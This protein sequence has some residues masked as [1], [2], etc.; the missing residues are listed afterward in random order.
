[1]LAGRWPGW[2][3]LLLTT[4]STAALVA[5]PAASAQTR[6]VSPTTRP[7]AVAP[8]VV[9]PTIDTAIRLA[10]GCAP[11]PELTGRH[12][13]EVLPRL[14]PELFRA[15][16]N[17][18]PS[19]QPRGTILRQPTTQL[20][21]GRLCWLD[22]AVSDGSLTRVPQLRGVTAGEAERALAAAD[23]RINTREKPSGERAGRIFDQKPDAGAEVPRGSMVVAI[24]A[25]ATER[26]S[27]ADAAAAAVAEAI[28]A[29]GRDAAPRP[30]QPEPAEETC[31]PLPV[32][33]GRS[34]D[35]VLPTLGRRYFR[36]RIGEEP[37]TEPR[38]TILRQ[39]VTVPIDGSLCYI[40]IAISDGSL[41]RVPQ[42]HGAT[43][44]EAE[45][46]LAEADLRIAIRESV[47]S[48]PAGRVF[49][50]KPRAGDEVPR[51]STVG[52]MIAVP[53]LFQVPDVMGQPYEEALA[54]LERFAVTRTPAASRRPPGEVTNQEPRPP[55]RRPAGAEVRL[56]VSDG[57]LVLVPPIE[58]RTLDSARA[59]LGE[60]DLR[61]EVEEQEGDL[62][63][64]LVA[65]QEPAGG[66]EVPRGSTVRVLVS[67]GLPVPDVVGRQLAEAAILLGRFEVQ[68][69]SLQARQP[70][71]EV[72]DQ[73]PRPPA[74][75]A[76]ASVVRVSV[77]D[78]S[79]VL[80]PQVEGEALA[81]A[82]GALAE[83]G[84]QAEVEE[85]QGEIEPGL[86]AAQAPSSGT[87]VARGSTVH[88][89]V[90]TGPPPPEVVDTPTV[91]PTD[92][93][94]SVVTDDGDGPRWPRWPAYLLALLAGSG[95][96][97][98]VRLRLRPPPAE[99]HVSARLESDLDS[100]TTTDA[101]VV[102]PQMHVS[103]R[104]DAGESQVR[105]EGDSP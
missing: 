29:S 60:A 83:V 88:L 61:A 69:S 46:A 62:A 78:G 55:A 92:G 24:V 70:E 85:Q 18:E 58:Q 5:T 19:S 22:V 28:V 98:A 66:T 74:R 51:Q 59:A 31:L 71:G 37:S 39:P 17:A 45:R 89:V 102:G 12:L 67:T 57:S 100:V 90:S 101:D 52:A 77:S 73:D 9:R 26:I 23:L 16:V 104:L 86:V 13:D 32:L 1:M 63:P 21:E 15:R 97:Y 76:A 40:D 68:Q 11:L 105:L 103:A 53:E 34:L 3:L 47:S 8:S 42:L 75:V 91:P 99:P 25:T 30:P 50:Q 82:R 14:S 93:T 27:P 64:G 38:G 54:Q 95:L 96:F 80:V 36:P 4:A 6:P 48:E 33:A 2:L 81:S 84:L 10:R 65:R 72:I 35:D 87:E 43:A 56:E 41:T 49:G 94:G 44:E 20:I 79:R 7:D